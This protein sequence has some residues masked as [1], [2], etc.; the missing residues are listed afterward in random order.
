MIGRME[1]WP[2]SV[3]L[4]RRY[5][6]VGRGV[7]TALAVLLAIGSVVRSDWSLAASSA[8]LFGLAG[9]ALIQLRIDQP[10]LDVL[11]AVGGLWILG[12]SL[13]REPAI[14][15]GELLAYSMFAAAA[16]YLGGRWL[17]MWL[18]ITTLSSGIVLIV[19]VDA[20]MSVRAI[21]ILTLIIGSGIGMLMH[22]ETGSVLRAEAAR[23]DTLFKLAPN[24]II[25]SGA[26]GNIG[27]ANDR[28]AEIFGFDSPECVEGSAVADF[29]PEADWDT[30]RGVVA[31]V[32][33]APGV[34]RKMG[35]GASLVGVRVDG[36]QFP[37]DVSIAT[38]EFDG[39]EV[40]IAVVRDDTE[41]VVT[42]RH[43]REMAESRL[44]LLASVSHE[45]RTPLT[46]VLGFAEVLRAE[47]AMPR[48]D[49]SVIVGEIAAQ[50]SEMTDIVEDLLVAARIDQES[51]QIA[52]VPVNV[53]VEIAAVLRVRGIE[54]S[55]QICE[56]SIAVGD[57]ERVR[58]VLRN[59]VKNAMDH[60]GPN[61]R[62]H[63]DEGDG[64]IL[65][66]VSDDGVPLTTVQQEMI[67]KPFHGA[68]SESSTPA[69]IGIG[70]SLSRYL[71]RRMGGDVL[72]RH[73]DGRTVFEFTLPA[74]S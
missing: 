23:W 38:T 27:K 12:E 37:L 24:G 1:M 64:M 51:L 33:P 19:R 25:V 46:A 41:R 47:E 49:I 13:V 71:A 31:D 44:Q 26:G 57:P 34:H 29:M 3:T 63:V 22:R 48:T 67:F 66:A 74:A 32:T 42:L 11:V 39:Q 65:I 55:T 52:T 73:I 36:T 72:Y 58:Q 60:G 21:A 62:I 54:I 40:L 50:A 69:P 9:V 68:R 20:A 56:D 10:R 2:T 70:L 18:A 6:R 14:V 5:I 7:T 61:L 8:V 4:H 59:L 30:L 28:F 53:D 17:G 45:V 16:T 43:L 15:V 35:T